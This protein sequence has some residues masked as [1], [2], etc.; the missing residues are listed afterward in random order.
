MCNTFVGELVEY[1][2]VLTYLCK[3]L[4]L[5]VWA[6]FHLKRVRDGGGEPLNPPPP[7]S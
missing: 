7:H 3:G 2:H 6:R 4:A 5:V 1:V